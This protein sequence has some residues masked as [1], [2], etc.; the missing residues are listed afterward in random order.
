MSLDLVSQRF[1][2]CLI[3]P[4]IAQRSQEHA[5]FGPKKREQINPDPIALAFNKAIQN[6]SRDDTRVL[7]N[8]LSC[9]KKPSRFRNC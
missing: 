5:A 1:H 2:V 7:P 3:G 8:R 4:A 6:L 9:S